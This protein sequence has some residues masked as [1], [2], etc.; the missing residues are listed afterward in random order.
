M[1]HRLHWTVPLSRLVYRLTHC[2]ERPNLFASKVS[3][4]FY[5]Q[6]HSLRAQESSI[7]PSWISIA[8]RIPAKLRTPYQTFLGKVKKIDKG[9]PGHTNRERFAPFVGSPP[10]LRSERHSSDDGM[11][12][13]I[14]VVPNLWFH[15]LRVLLSK[16]RDTNSYIYSQFSISTNNEK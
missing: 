13:P 1:S 6:R 8:H 11:L 3:L 16:N 4:N 14:Q 9:L 15:T 10:I 2:S 7:G 12:M 5:S